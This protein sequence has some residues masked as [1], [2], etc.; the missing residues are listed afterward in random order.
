MVAAGIAGLLAI[1]AIVL[2]AFALAKGGTG[3]TTTI[4]ALEPR[5]RRDRRARRRGRGVVGDRPHARAHLYGWRPEPRGSSSP[6]CS[7]R[8]VVTC[9]A[10]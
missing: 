4:V 2:G 3:E 10:S 9:T 6:A 5:R 1:V 8:P 7:F